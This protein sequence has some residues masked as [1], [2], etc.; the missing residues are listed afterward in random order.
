MDR[1]PQTRRKMSVKYW[2]ND[3]WPNTASTLPPT[4][5]T[6]TALVLS[7]S[8]LCDFDPPIRPFERL[9]FSMFFLITSTAC[10]NFA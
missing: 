3:D 4:D 5:P 7:S 6:L 10:E 1:E 8:F 9:Q 2:W